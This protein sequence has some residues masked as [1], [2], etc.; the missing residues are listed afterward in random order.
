MRDAPLHP[1]RVAS[2]RS[3]LALKIISRSRFKN[4]ARLRIRGH[5]IVES[6]LFF[7][8]FSE[9]ARQEIVQATFRQCFRI[10]VRVCTLSLADIPLMQRCILP[11]FFPFTDT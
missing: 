10:F 9:V 3:D 1:P 5:R 11:A 4:N 6:G 2:L 8:A 7:R